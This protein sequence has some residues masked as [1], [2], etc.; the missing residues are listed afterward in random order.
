MIKG[1]GS[2]PETLAQNIYSI[3][4]QFYE[5]KFGLSKYVNSDVVFKFLDKFLLGELEREPRLIARLHFFWNNRK[6]KN[7]EAD[8]EQ[9]VIQLIRKEAHNIIRDEPNLLRSIGNE[10]ITNS[11]LDQ[12]WFEFVNRISNRLLKNFAN[13]MIDSMAGADILNVFQSIG[14]AGALYAVMAPYF[15]SYSIFSLDRQFSSEMLDHFQGNSDR[16]LTSMKELNV[17]HFTDTFYEVNGVTGT[18]K[19][20]IEE[21]RSRNRRYTVITCDER[22]RESGARVKNFRP[23]GVYELSV[24]PEQK[25]FYPPFLEILS[26]CYK[27]EFNQIHAA[28]PGPIGLAAMAIA[29]ILKV[30]FVGT[31]HTALPQ[32]AQY[33]TEDPAIANMVWRYIIWFYDQMDTIFVPSRATA[34]ELVEHGISKSRIRLMPRGVDSRE[35]HPEK[36]NPGMLR[37]ELGIPEGFK[38]LYVGRVSKEKNLKLLENAFAKLAVFKKNIQLVIVGDGPYFEE[39]RNNL[40]DFPAYFTGYLTGERLRSVFASCDLFVFPSVTDTF[41]NVVLEAQASGLPVIVTDQGGPCENI[42]D[43]KTGFIIKGNNEQELLRSMNKA[44]SSPSTLK[45]MGILAR[46]YAESRSLNKAFDG[47]WRLYEQAHDEKNHETRQTTVSIFDGKSA[48]NF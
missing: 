48:A 17:A 21:A 26:Y 7:T 43:G 11:D 8:D 15:V 36:R 28:T 6:R 22:N 19:K 2:H 31:Y 1:H 4:Y 23:I 16:S 35:F 40:R 29:R 20:Q 32:Y 25:L 34:Q 24:Y 13:Q 14:S 12:K 38:L 37:D 46:R 10:T 39:M 44:I 5:D 9:K 47:I 27:K 33:L 18:L 42:V 45:E 30:P 41:G 3:A